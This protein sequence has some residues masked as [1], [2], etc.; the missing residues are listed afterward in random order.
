MFVYMCVL[1]C[2]KVFN[3]FKIVV[4]NM[5][6]KGKKKTAAKIK[7]KKKEEK[8]EKKKKD[9]EK[10]VKMNARY[11]STSCLSQIIQ[12]AACNIVNKLTVKASKDD[13]RKSERRDRDRD[14]DK[15]RDR[16]RDRGGDRESRDRRRRKK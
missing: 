8:E 16:D 5:I 2:K 9:V 1:S 15:D 10:D 3:V 4:L 7:E 14:R 6:L 11:L 13:K 12:A